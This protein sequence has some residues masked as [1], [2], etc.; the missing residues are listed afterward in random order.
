MLTAC[1]DPT[2]VG[3]D[4]IGDRGGEP[5]VREVEPSVFAAAAVPEVTG[6]NERSLLGYVADPVLGTIRSNAYLD[7]APPGS[8][9]DF[10]AGT[11]DF[12]SLE[13]RRTYVFGDT[14]GDVTV[15]LYDIAEDWSAQGATQDTSFA[16]GDHIATYTFSAADSLVQ[17]ELPED[18]VARNDTTLRSSTFSTV[19]HG[20][21]IEGESGEA[22]IGFSSSGTQMRA[23]AGAD[24]VV[25]ALA[26]NLTTVE[27]QGDVPEERILVQG[28]SGRA[29]EAEFDVQ[30]LRDLYALNRAVIRLREDSL[31]SESALPPDYVRPRA[32]QLNLFVRL[33]DGN[34]LLADSATRTE[35]GEFVFRSTEFQVL[36]DQFLRGNQDIDG[37][38]FRV[39]TSPNS[40]DHVFIRADEAASPRL[41]L[42]LTPLLD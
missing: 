41:T 3:I 2:S 9:T 20:F 33:P 7:F 8:A 11:V 29:L 27:T 37:F 4:I 24:S 10:R 28:A 14:L 31:L 38:V 21:Y 5:V 1:E 35:D 39:P 12:A 26:R 6:N 18:W 30:E 25:F 34:L 40:L 32:R 15:S 13:L 23:A 22:V 19:F 17:L 42:T 16:R 36:L